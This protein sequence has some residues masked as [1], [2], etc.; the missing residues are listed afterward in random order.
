[1]TEFFIV[2]NTICQSLRPTAKQRNQ[3]AVARFHVSHLASLFYSD[4]VAHFSDKRL[5][6]FLVL[7][8]RFVIVFADANTMNLSVTS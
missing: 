5:G 7:R 4:D 1:M 2:K 3:P 8:E 6:S